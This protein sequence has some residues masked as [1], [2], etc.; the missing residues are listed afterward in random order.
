MSYLEEAAEQL[1]RARSA[2]EAR[3]GS[4]NSWLTEGAV[5]VLTEVNQRRMEIADGFI[6][7]A[8][9]ERA[10]VSPAADDRIARALSYAEDGL[11]DGDHHKTWVIDQIVR[12]L[13]GCPVITKTAT[14]VNDREYGYEA[15]GESEA[16]L[17]FVYDAGEWVEGIAPLWRST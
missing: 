11:P 7:I 13:T 4:V 6:R 5:P 16:Y 2:N 3:A 14:D 9:I 15:Q 8:A 10:A 1:R 17:R 12:A